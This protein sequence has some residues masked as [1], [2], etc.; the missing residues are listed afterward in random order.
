MFCSGPIT[1]SHINRKRD[2]NLL[3]VVKEIN[4]EA[5]NKGHREVP[6]NY[7]SDEGFQIYL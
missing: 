4:N 6:M 2:I 3:M 7:I 5:V 1:L